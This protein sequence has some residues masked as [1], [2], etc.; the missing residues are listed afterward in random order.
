M[1]RPANLDPYLAC[2]AAQR[3]PIIGIDAAFERGQGQGAIHEAGV[4][5]IGP[6][7]LSERMPDVV[8]PAI[9]I[10]VQYPGASPEAVENDVTKPI[11]LVVNTVNGVLIQRTA[12]IDGS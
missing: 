9:F 7:P 11:E 4:D 5:E 10:Q 8:F 6:D 2:Q 3:L 1:A 12:T